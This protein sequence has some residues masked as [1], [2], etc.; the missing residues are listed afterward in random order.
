M[1]VLFQNDFAIISQESG[2][3]RLRRTNVPFTRENAPQTTQELVT[4]FRLAIPL[5][6]RRTIGLLIDSREALMMV[7]GEEGIEPLRPMVAEMLLGFPR[8]AILVKTA[9]GKLQAT[10][11][12]RE[13]PGEGTTPRVFDDEAAAIAFLRGEET[14]PP[15]RSPKSQS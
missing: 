5:R 1:Q 11:L 2:L 6:E 7:V 12:V 9:V 4:R 13:E 10:R 8:I 15:T 3:I 14:A